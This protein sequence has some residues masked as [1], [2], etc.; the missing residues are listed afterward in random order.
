MSGFRSYL[1]L[2]R[3]QLL[4]YR[5]LLPLLAGIQVALG[6]GVIFGFSFLV[7][8]LTPTVV[9]YFATGAPTLS[10]ILMGLTA[11]PQEIAQDRSTGKFTYV[12]ALPVPRLAPMLADVTFWMLI[13]LP[14]AVVTLLLANLR[15]GLHLDVSGLVVPAVILVALTASA[16]G[17]AIAVALPPNAT[18][19]VSS[20]VSIALL[21]FSPINFPLGRLPVWLQDVHRALP[22]TY[23][24]D[25]MRGGLTGRYDASRWLAFAVVAAWCALGLTVSGRA[26]RHRG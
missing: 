24:S 23:M 5:P 7:P 4:R 16:V 17:Y 8:H 3:W 22:V 18:S 20:F 19:Q 15:F 25:I 13:Q 9:L 1:L 12:A 6:V 10:L 21:L 14:G 11:L 2:L 26:A